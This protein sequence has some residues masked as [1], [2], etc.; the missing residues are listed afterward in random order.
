MW[1]AVPRVVPHRLWYWLSDYL[2]RASPAPHSRGSLRDPALDRGAIHDYETCAH[3]A[4][5]KQSKTLIG[6]TF[7]P[8]EPL[9]VDDNGQHEQCGDENPRAVWKVLP[10]NC[11]G[12]FI[13]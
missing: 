13:E 7:N 6:S 11:R 1:T 5:K 9:L 4:L 2:T 8:F 10:Y 3:R 12:Q